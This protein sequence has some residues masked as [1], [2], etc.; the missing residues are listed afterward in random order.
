MRPGS[1][2]VTR[3]RRLATTAVLGTAACLV[4]G[5]VMMAAHGS[6]RPSPSPDLGAAPAA[7]PVSA[8]AGR[9]LPR[10]AATAFKVASLTS[11]TSLPADC[12][13][14]PAG[15]PGAPYQLGLVGTVH[16]GT[17]TAGPAT[18]AN[19]N[20]T[21]CGVVTVV[22]GTPPCGA[23]GNVV[24]PLDGQVFGPLSVALTL[25][26]GMNPTIGFAANPG[27]IT[28]GFSCGTSVNG[29]NVTLNATVSGSTGA[30][31]GVSCTIGPLTIPLAGAVTGPFTDM[32]ATLTSNNFSVPVV[33]GSATCPGGV[34]AN[35]DAIA[36]LP[37]APGGASATLPITASLY[38]PG[39]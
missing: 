34:P 33:Q 26:P 16:G 4:A 10:G 13:P 23:T 15:P 30:L 2:T 25:V 18:V 12:I 35:I 39:P 8:A 6:V 1:K 9:A 3:W 11:A 31:F 36:G 24:S 32:T 5:S 29:L 27:T 17:L 22:G 28:G 37:I 7:A 14:N 38:Q 20:V 19:I 21:F